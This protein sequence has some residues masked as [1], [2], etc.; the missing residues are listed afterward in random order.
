MPSQP[1]KN[2]LFAILLLLIVLSAAGFVFNNARQAEASRPPGATL[3]SQSVLEEQYGLRVNLIAIT[4][5]GGMVDLRLKIVDGEKAKVL[6]ADKKN[7]PA[8]FLKGI[9][10]NTPEDTK[11]QKIEFTTGA[12]L[13]VM[14]PNSGNAARRDAP[15]T[16]LFGDIAIEPITAK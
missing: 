15:V 9:T 1:R 7:F 8:L 10:L 13:F 11:S 2:I 3:I 14:Y 4:A 6:L 12:N 16:I 5:A